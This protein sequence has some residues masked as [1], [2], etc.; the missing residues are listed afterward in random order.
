MNI[1]SLPPFTS[2]SAPLHSILCVETEP[3][4]ARAIVSMVTRARWVSQ[5][6]RGVI[7][8]SLIAHLAWSTV[9]QG[10][11]DLM[12]R[13]A[14]SSTSNPTFRRLSSTCDG[15]YMSGRLLPSCKIINILLRD[16]SDLSVRSKFD[17]VEFPVCQQR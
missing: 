3:L 10:T 16:F 1:P 4:G 17:L 7:F 12:A 11:G 5:R 15:V 9:Y 2:P 8:R 13:S 14:S 6:P